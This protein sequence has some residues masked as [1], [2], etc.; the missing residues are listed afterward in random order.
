MVVGL[1]GGV[2]GPAIDITAELLALGI[3]KL[4]DHEDSTAQP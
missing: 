1:L 2:Q 3:L 4:P